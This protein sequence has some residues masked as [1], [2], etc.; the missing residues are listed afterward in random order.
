MRSI[1]IVENRNRLCRL[2]PVALLTAALMTLPM[3]AARAA[4]PITEEEAHAIGVDAYVYF[5]PL[6]SM[7][8]TRKQLTNV[9]AKPRARSAVRPTCST[10]SPS[11][12]RRT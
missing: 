11:F 2:P 7:D 9:E 10:T 1:S 6:L 3:V 4:D 5:Y 12:R 8:V